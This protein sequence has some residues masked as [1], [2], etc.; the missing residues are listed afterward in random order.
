MI[1]PVKMVA[2]YC[3]L[4]ASVGASHWAAYTFLPSS[5]WFRYESLTVEGF[6]PPGGPIPVVSIAERFRETDMAYYDILYCDLMDGQG[7]QYYSEYRSEFPAAPPTD[8][9]VRSPWKYQGLTPL[10]GVCRIRSA[11]SA[12]G[13][14]GVL[15]SPPD[16]KFTQFFEIGK[17]AKP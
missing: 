10:K 17:V 13:P 12:K 1:S 6:V 5:F 3:L 9:L 7:V 2:G 14:F 8:G 4:M 16:I 15:T 11:T